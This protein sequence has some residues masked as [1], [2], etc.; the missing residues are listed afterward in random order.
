MIPRNAQLQQRRNA[1]QRG[2]NSTP[3]TP[4]A[5]VDSA[6][7]AA[8]RASEAQAA[9]QP[10]DAKLTAITAAAVAIASLPSAASSAWQR[11]FVNDALAPVFG[12]TVANGGAAVV[13]VFSNG[14]NWIV[15]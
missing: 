6:A 9:S 15:G 13:P 10:L 3:L 7:D 8:N 12:A 5:S 14:T 2:I 1:M 11:R 4:H